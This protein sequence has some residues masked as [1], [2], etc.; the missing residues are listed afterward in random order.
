[1][2]MVTS[3]F[4]II[5]RIHLLLLLTSYQTTLAYITINNAAEA[6]TLWSS[7]AFEI[8]LDVRSQSEWNAGHLP[9]ATLIP[10]LHQTKDTSR[11]TGCEECPIAIY[12]TGGVRSKWAAETLESA[13]FRNVYD[14]LGTDQWRD[15]GIVLV[16]DVENAPCC[17]D[18]NN[19]MNVTTPTV[20]SNGS[21]DG[22]RRVIVGILINMFGAM[23]L[24]LSYT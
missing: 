8:L 15:A 10:S 4:H 14:V 17:G 1:M 13:G 11:I 2:M 5:L 21:I 18:C 19:C 9:N 6:Y 12:C 23:L 16:N 20:I 3:S 24:L 7:G 22:S